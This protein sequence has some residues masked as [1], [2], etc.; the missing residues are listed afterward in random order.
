MK[1]MKLAPIAM[2]LTLALGALPAAAKP[3]VYERGHVGIEHL[4]H[5]LA[6]ATEE[7]RDEVATSRRGWRFNQ[8]Y[9]LRKLSR[10]QHDAAVFHRR[11]ER[12]GLY[13]HSTRR[14][15]H[16]LEASFAAANERI[17]AMTHRRSIR[18]D[19]LQVAAL[20]ERL[21]TRMA[22]LDHH[23]DGRGHAGNHREGRWSIAGNFGH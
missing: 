8:R 18:H 21:E 22:R 3:R 2:I 11:V 7:L 20:M 16:E 17:P 10:L 1:A 12:V 14:A 5:K 15:F 23:R 19:F 4:S 6:T 9:T 13:D